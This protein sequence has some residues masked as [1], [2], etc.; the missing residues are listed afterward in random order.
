MKKREAV[1]YLIISIAVFSFLFFAG[2]SFYTLY[3]DSTVYLSYTKHTGV[4]P[5]YQIF[6]QIN[7]SFFGEDYFLYAV[8]VEQTILATV[9]CMSFFCFMRTYFTVKKLSAL[10]MLVAILMPFAINLPTS[11]VNRE[12]LTEA[13]SYPFFYIFMI[14]VIRAVVEKNRKIFIVLCVCSC[15]M[16]MIRTQLQLTFGIVAF[17]WFYLGWRKCDGKKLSFKFRKSIIRVCQC[18]GIVAGL[19]LTLLVVNKAGQYIILTTGTTGG[20]ENRTAQ[21]DNVT[22]QYRSLLIDKTLYEMDYED[23]QLFENEEIRELYLHIFKEAELK[24]NRYIYA[25]NGLWKWQDIMNGIAGGTNV[26]HEGVSSYQAAYPD[27]E[28]DCSQAV[29]RICIKLL[30]AHWGR[31]LYH[32]LCL[33]PVAMLCTV[34]F[35]IEEIYL[36]CHFFAFAAYLMAIL[37]TM[38][39]YRKEKEDS[40]YWEGMAVCISVNL[41]WI[42]VLSLFFFGMQRYMIYGFGPFWSMVYILF[43]RIQKNW[44]RN[45]AC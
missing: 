30:Q 22:V 33:I 14:F 6:L 2:E 15:V 39:Q 20:G 13:F 21:S 29:D 43:L 8:A 17:V 28:L 40:K 16:A 44:K 32:F 37:L 31:M 9:C 34:F 10:P 23:S 27:S 4:M 26:L 42:F 45:N 5:F 24:K 18:C 1:Y 38:V 12:I 11:M 36:L 35:Q 7:R 3:I 25:R 19:F 41:I